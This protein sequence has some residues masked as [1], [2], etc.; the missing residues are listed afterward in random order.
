M[1]A[2]AGESR[3]ARFRTARLRRLSWTAAAAVAVAAFTFGAVDEG[4][5]LTNADR[6]S[7]L[8]RDF[9][10]PVC[11]GQSVADSDVPVSREIRR[12]IAVWVDEGRS[13]AYI[14]DQLVAAYGDEIDYNPSASGVTSLVWILPVLAGGG[15]L[16][17]L[18][19]LLAGSRSEPGRRLPTRRGIRS[20]HDAGRAGGSGESQDVPAAGPPDTPATGPQDVPAAGP[21]DAPATGPRRRGAITAWAV[22]VVAVSATAGVSVARIA[23]SRYADG[24]I[25]GSIRSTSR[26]LIFQAQNL[27]QDGD[28]AGAIGAYDEALALQPSNPEALTYRGWLTSRAGDSAAA[29]GYLDDAIGVDPGYPDAR[30]FRAIVALELDDGARA[31]AELA[32]FDR[33]DPPPY[34]EAL[35]DRAN[36]RARVAEARDA[37]IVEAMESA[38]D[39]RFDASGF[40]PG[41]ALAAAES[42][43]ARGR[44]LDAV[45]LLDWVS[46]SHP[47][48]A[49]VWAGRGWLLAR[50]RDT[51]LLEHAIAYLDKALEADSEQPQAL[52]FSALAR[53]WRWEGARAPQAAPPADSPDA[54]TQR[55]GA[56]PGDDDLTDDDI[57][58]ARAHLA[59]FGSLEDQPPGLLALIEAEG[60][61]EALAAAEAAAAG[62][63][64][65]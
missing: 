30:L 63:P 32:E 3:I 20:E 15:I 21:P 62:M 27:L 24:S 44:L 36:V 5:P 13:D 41:E 17:V 55:R 31:A 18:A 38:H 56:A 1:S 22:L 39:S 57:A 2:G 12:R 9:A 51:E 10:C 65:R 34:A 6:V 26:E 19:T 16:L 40:T 64:A 48:D 8:A 50:S 43:A 59:A 45:K 60:L 49:A 46:R 61:E 14:R 28:T 7:A 35:L 23:G 47:E 37:A 29:V 11:S 52:V 42:L 53:L 4:P 54:Q 33:L 58:A 25:T